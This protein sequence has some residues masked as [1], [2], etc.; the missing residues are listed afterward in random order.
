MVHDRAPVD[1][2]IILQSG[3]FAMIP[4]R[5]RLPYKRAEYLSNVLDYD[6]Q[7]STSICSR[8]SV[9]HPPCMI[10]MVELHGARPARKEDTVFKV[11]MKIDQGSMAIS[12]FEIGSRAKKPLLI[13]MHREY[14]IHSLWRLHCSK[15]PFL[16]VSQYYMANGSDLLISVITTLSSPSSFVHNYFISLSAQSKP[17][18][19][20]CRYRRYILN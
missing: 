5:T 2:G 10:Q 9:L 3:F 13:S 1:I 19:R 16:E 14:M 6:T 20:L 17:S 18:G 8:R 15:T 7:T 11:T 4:A 12:H